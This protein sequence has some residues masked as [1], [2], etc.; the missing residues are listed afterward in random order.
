MSPLKMSREHAYAIRD[1]SAGEYPTDCL[2]KLKVG[3]STPPPPK[4]PE[5]RG[6]KE[7]G[8]GQLGCHFQT[9]SY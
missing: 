3:A 5:L 8:G 2:R 4:S 1:V 9:R 6:L 7:N